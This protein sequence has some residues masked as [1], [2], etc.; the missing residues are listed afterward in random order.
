[1]ARE[2]RRFHRRM[3]ARELRP[4]ALQSWRCGPI[5]RRARQGPRNGQF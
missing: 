4:R 5:V 1:M 3:I 2:R